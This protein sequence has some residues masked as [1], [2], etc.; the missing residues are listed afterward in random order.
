MILTS[1]SVS[2][3]HGVICKRSRSSSTSALDAS[4]EITNGAMLNNWFYSIQS[5]PNV[6]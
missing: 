3:M 5:N 4:P 6:K 2:I 1:N